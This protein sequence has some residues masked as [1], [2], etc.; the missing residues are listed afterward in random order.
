MMWLAF[1]VPCGPLPSIYPSHCPPY[2]VAG[3][4]E[5]RMASD[6]HYPVKEADRR[7]QGLPFCF[8]LLAVT[9]NKLC[10]F[11]PS[12]YLCLFVTTGDVC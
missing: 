10:L 9:T 2:V 5:G 3:R 4:R 7:R 6:R 1:L 11:I 8:Y 12:V